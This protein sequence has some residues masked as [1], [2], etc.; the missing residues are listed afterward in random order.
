MAQTAVFPHQRRLRSS[1]V[2]G[3]P[4]PSEHIYGKHTN[5]DA[6]TMH[7]C[8]TLL[9]ICTMSVFMCVSFVCGILNCPGK[10]FLVFDISAFCGPGMLCGTKFTML[11]VAHVLEFHTASAHVFHVCFLHRLYLQGL[12]WC[13]HVYFSHLLACRRMWGVVF[14]SFITFV[15]ISQGPC[16]SLACDGM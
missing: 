3:F 9:H 4:K 12:V 7:I 15:D 13:T 11:F 5:T 8:C 10:R 16:I 6:Q 2:S 1:K 14:M